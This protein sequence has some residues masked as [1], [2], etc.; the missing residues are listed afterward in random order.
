MDFFHANDCGLDFD[1][2][3]M[4]AKSNYLIYQC[5][6]QKKYFI[7]NQQYSAFY[8]EKFLQKKVLLYPK[9]GSGLS[10]IFFWICLGDMPSGDL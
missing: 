3:M 8:I 4:V 5:F 9:V 10:R 1:K 2:K 7:E 6:C